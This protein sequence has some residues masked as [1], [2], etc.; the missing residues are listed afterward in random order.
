MS[1]DLTRNLTW[2]LNLVGKNIL[3]N[4]KIWIFQKLLLIEKAYYP[5]ILTTCAYDDIFYL[6]NEKAD[7]YIYVAINLDK[8]KKLI[9]TLISHKFPLYK[10]NIFTSFKYKSPYNYIHVMSFLPEHINEIFNSI[11][12]ISNVSL[13]YSDVLYDSLRKNPN[14]QNIKDLVCFVDNPMVSVRDGRL[15]KCTHTLKYI[16]KYDLMV[17]EYINFDVLVALTAYLIYHRNDK[18]ATKAKNK[19]MYQQ[20]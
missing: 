2:L 13:N 6:Y 1:S 11:H 19:I 18:L 3:N 7:K 5:S 20:L 9:D 14:M 15:E 16:D 10:V 17:R 4:V 8:V 12:I